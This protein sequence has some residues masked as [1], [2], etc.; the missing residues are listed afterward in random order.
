[1]FASPAHPAPAACGA[2]V[3]N[4]WSHSPQD[5]SR[6]CGIC[7]QVALTLV[8]EH[9]PTPTWSG[10]DMIPYIKIQIMARL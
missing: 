7:A 3:G 10:V 6:C 1:M 9:L 5:L 2:P 4:S 8:S